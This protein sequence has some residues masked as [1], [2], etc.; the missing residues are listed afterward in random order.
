MSMKPKFEYPRLEEA[1]ET[2]KQRLHDVDSEHEHLL[3]KW[4]EQ[5]TKVNKQMRQLERIE[6]FSSA[7]TERDNDEQ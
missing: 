3:N 1:I 4:L 7:L 2:L 5:L 6:S